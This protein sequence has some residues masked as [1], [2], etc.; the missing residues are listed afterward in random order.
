MNLSLR[1]QLLLGALLL[2][3]SG[4]G[5]RNIARARNETAVGSGVRVLDG[6]RASEAAAFARLLED[7]AR[8]DRP[9]LRQR[10]EELQQ[11]GVLWVAPGMDAGHWALYVDTF[12][13]VR[14]IYIREIALVSP[15]AHLFPRGAEG[16]PVPQQRAFA[17]VS[18]AGA[19]FHELQH[20]D[21]IEDE[22]AAYDREIAWLEGLRAAPGL[23]PLAEPERRSL[24]WGI[25]SALLSARKARSLAIG[26]PDRS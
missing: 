12:R 16:I 5:I 21:G 1:L 13:L 19:L 17:S 15:E 14:R 20:F 25:E 4:V 7:I 6:A 26:G 23:A 9:D 22:A 8:L 3:A 24:D 11:R 10:L 18:L 2:V